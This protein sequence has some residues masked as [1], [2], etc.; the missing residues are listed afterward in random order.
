MPKEIK[1]HQ[2]VLEA[3]RS[4]DI[5][6]DLLEKQDGHFQ[7]ELDL[8]VIAYGRN[9]NGKKVG[10]YVHLYEYDSG[11]EVIREGDWGGNTFYITVEGSLD[12]F[13]RDRETGTDE[14][15]G[16]IP[17]GVSFGEMS[18]LA[19]VPR[20]ATVRVPAGAKARALEVSRPALRLLRKL[21]KFGQ[22]LD[23]N[24]RKHGLSRTLI[25]IEH[26]TGDAFPRAL[27]DRLGKSARFMV[28]AK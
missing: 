12:V 26:A 23:A 18:I 15:V 4:V 14:K 28:Y 2:T 7:Y 5:I 19:G 16:V 24:Y 9:Y 17:P 11:E 21:P 1:K 8:E 10:P 22:M 3:I 13:V 20:N 27:L 6:S 25:D